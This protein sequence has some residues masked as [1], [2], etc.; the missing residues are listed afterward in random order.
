MVD[1]TEFYRSRLDLSRFRVFVGLCRRCGTKA[2]AGKTM[3]AR[4]LAAAV[5]V[6]RIAR[7]EIRAR[8]LNKYGGECACCGEARKEFLTIDHVDGNGAGK[9]HRAAVGNTPGVYTDL[10]SRP[11]DLTKYRV[12]CM[13][14]NSSHS[15]YGYCPHELENKQAK[16]EELV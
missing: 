1:R 9:A 6:V 5:V 15:W 7:T 4:H 16:K 3:C 2:V 13:N 11:A 12:L 8:V 10:D 14:C